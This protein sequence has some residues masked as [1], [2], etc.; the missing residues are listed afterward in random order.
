VV[1]GH[2]VS[3][4]RRER[5]EV[6]GFCRDL[7]PADW[8]TPSAADGWRVQD[9]VAHLAASS[10]AIFTPAAVTLMTTADIERTNDDFVDRRR[11][12]A[13]ASVLAE[14]AAWSARVGRLAAVV[15]RTPARRAPMPL[16]E[17]GLFPTGLVLTGAFTFDLHTHLR[18]DLAPALGRT[19]PTSDAE[20]VDVVLAWMLAVL[21]STLRRHPQHAPDEPVVL[22]LR[23]PGGGAWTVQPD[24]A[25]AHGALARTRVSSAAVDFP[26]WATRRRPWRDHDVTVTGDEDVATRFLDALRVV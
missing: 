12:A 11:D 25:L 26:S 4:L 24:G 13:P 8:A 9:V 2:R 1:V 7:S 15:E 22:D 5:D 14:F 18:H 20:R 21:E 10:R 19:P 16:G 3:A 17:L 6:L 23:G